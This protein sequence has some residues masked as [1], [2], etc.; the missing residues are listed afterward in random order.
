MDLVSVNLLACFFFTN[1]FFLF[2]LFLRLGSRAV[3]KPQCLPKKKHGIVVGT[4]FPL[5]KE[6]QQ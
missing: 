2:G 6:I 4:L 5:C 1:F 3:K